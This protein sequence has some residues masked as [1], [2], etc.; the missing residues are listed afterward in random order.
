MTERKPLGWG[1]LL[2]HF[3]YSRCEKCRRPWWAA[4]ARVVRYTSARGQFAL[5]QRCWNRS[6][7]EERIDAH[8]WVTFVFQDGYHADEWSLIEAAVR[9]D[10]R[11]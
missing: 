1:L 5:C 10:K 6:T 4:E 7:E 2:P 8:H 3:G 9:K 11:Y